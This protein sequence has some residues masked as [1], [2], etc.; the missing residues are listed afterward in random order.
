M[1]KKNK[2]SPVE[3]LADALNKRFLELNQKLPKNLVKFRAR[4]LYAFCV[5]SGADVSAVCRCVADS[6]LNRLFVPAALVRAAVA[7]IEPEPKFTPTNE[8]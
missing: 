4:R 8:N 3:F 6:D 2:Q 1:A 5:A 7:Y